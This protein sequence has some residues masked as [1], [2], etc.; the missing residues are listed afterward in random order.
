VATSSAGPDD[1]AHDGGP[2][3]GVRVVEFANF[4]AGPYAGQ[5][6]AD[7]GADVVKVESAAGD[8]FRTFAGSKYSPSFVAFNRNKR[9]VVLDLRSAHGQRAALE[10]LKRADV[11]LENSRPGVMHRL[12][13]GYDAVRALNPGIVYCSLSGF[14]QAGPAAGRATFDTVAQAVGGLLGQLMDSSDPRIVGPAFADGLSGL[15]GAYA[16]LAA[17]VDKQRHGTGQYLDVSMFSSVASFLTNEA[18]MWFATGDP[19]GPTRRPSLSQSFAFRCAGDGAVAVHLS[20]PEKFWVG[21]LEAT[22]RQDLMTDPRFATRPQRTENYQALHAALAG[23]FAKHTVTQWCE[24][25]DHFD[26]PNAPVNSIKDV[27]EEPQAKFIGLE[28]PLEHETEGRVIT[29]APAVKFAGL[30][31]AELKAPP[32]L[33][34]HTDEVLAE[35][36]LPLPTG[37][38]SPEL[39]AR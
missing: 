8:P 5:L 23:E 2:L 27:F 39:G 36:G 30:S 4:I 22:G 26:V 19:G 34:Q 35:I 17:L 9:S 7:L 21:L 16:I 6:L 11:L 10:L 13:L 12:G 18:A 32:A 25:L 1:A 24:K 31:W 20:S 37:S 29:V 3:A 14:G 28:L 33:G 15:T 38:T